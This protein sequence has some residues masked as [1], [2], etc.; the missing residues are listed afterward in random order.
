MPG[1][2]ID[3]RSEGSDKNGKP[4]IELYYS[5]DK[6]ASL[7]QKTAVESIEGYDT[8]AYAVSQEMG[9]VESRGVREVPTT[10]ALDDDY[11]IERWERPTHADDILGVLDSW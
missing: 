6:P 2:T 10:I 11:E 7:I 4:H 8:E 5:E 9:K 3:T 1:F